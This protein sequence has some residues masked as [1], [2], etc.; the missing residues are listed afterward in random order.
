M[1]LTNFWNSKI[2]LGHSGFRL[3]LA[4]IINAYGP[5]KEHR[6]IKATTLDENFFIL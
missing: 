5:E 3:F 1:T 2:E 6:N 4:L